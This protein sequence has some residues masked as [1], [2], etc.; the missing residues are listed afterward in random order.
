MRR[1]EVC[2]YH[3][4]WPSMFAAEAEQLKQIFGAE[5]T[6][7]YH[8]GSTSVPGLQAKPIID[9]M[10]IVKK[11]EIIDT[12]NDQMQEIGYTPK[13]EN[14]IPQRR[15][16]QKGD[17]NRSH[18]VHIYQKG[19]HQITRHLAFREYLRQHPDERNRYGQLKVKLADQFPYDISSYIDGKGNLV[20]EIEAKALEWY[21]DF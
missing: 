20:K 11:L 5:L 6:A 21:K 13:G 9:I 12:Y 17:D 8:I 1:V 10:P 3:N 14:G 7:I 16:F 2:S 4:K 19:S 18:H 15:Y